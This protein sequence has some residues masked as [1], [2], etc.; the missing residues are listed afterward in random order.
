MACCFLKFKYLYWFRP[1]R[2]GGGGGYD[3]TFRDLQWRRIFE[4]LKIG[5]NLK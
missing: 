5:R 3:I 4:Q 1:F 2:G